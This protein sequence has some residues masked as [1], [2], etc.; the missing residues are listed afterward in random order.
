MAFD[1]DDCYDSYDSGCYVGDNVDRG[2][3]DD[4]EGDEFGAVDDFLTK[5]LATWYLRFPYCCRG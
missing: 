4:I 5:T 2:H 3:I 1:Y